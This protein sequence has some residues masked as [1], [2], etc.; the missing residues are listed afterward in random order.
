MLSYRQPMMFPQDGHHVQGMLQRF[1][2]PENVKE[3]CQ[4]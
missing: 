2:Q 4:K 1:A 3:G